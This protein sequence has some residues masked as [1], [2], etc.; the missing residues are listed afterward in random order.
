MAAE[1]AKE[2][3]GAVRT[4][5]RTENRTDRAVSPARGLKTAEN[6]RKA[7]PPK[8]ASLKEVS[9][10]EVSPKETFPKENSRKRASQATAVRYDRRFFIKLIL[11]INPP[12]PFASICG[13][14]LDYSRQTGIE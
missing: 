4:A 10:R 13:G 2:E 3:N 9:L 5:A 6:V 12:G 1:T 14:P 11:R 7:I 8:A